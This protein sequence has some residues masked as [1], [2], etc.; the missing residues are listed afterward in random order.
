V[1]SPR[2]L[3]HGALR[4][5]IVIA[6]IAAGGVS[7]MAWSTASWH[8]SGGSPVQ[9]RTGI[10]SGSALGSPQPMAMKTARIA[11]TTARVEVAN[12]RAS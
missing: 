3:L 5:A 2:C 11:M 4:H 6:T 1:D 8:M 9:D 12:G 7:A 10:P